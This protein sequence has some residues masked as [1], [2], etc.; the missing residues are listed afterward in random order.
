MRVGLGF[1]IHR[2]V[3]GGPLRLGGV[4]IP[5]GK[6]LL[7]HS[8][9]DVLLHA[10]CDALLGAVGAGDIGT[11]FPDTDPRWKGASSER[12]MEKAMDL[13]SRR[14]LRVANVDGVVLAEEPKLAPHRASIQR[15][16]AR[17][18]GVKEDRV[19]IKA[20]TMERMGPIGAAEAIAASVV[21]LLEE[22]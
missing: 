19:N 11:H 16:V 13:A 7:G 4:Q 10:L 22:R 15:S 6:G 1:D 21:V 5:H 12:F 18:L 2:L 9:G 17:L 14:C 3:D 20:K 8:D